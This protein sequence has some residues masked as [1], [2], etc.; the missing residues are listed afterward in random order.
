[1]EEAIIYATNHL[2]V[3]HSHKHKIHEHK[4]RH[5]KRKIKLLPETLQRIQKNMDR[6]QSINS[7]A[8]REN[9]SNSAIHKAIKSG[10]LSKN[11]QSIVVTKT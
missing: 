6:G 11:T 9:V 8:K 4:P 1:M 2:L 5:K 3:F 7:I 10:K